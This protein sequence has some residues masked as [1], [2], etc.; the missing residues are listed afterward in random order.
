LQDEKKAPFNQEHHFQNDSYNREA[1]TVVSPRVITPS[2]IIPLNAVQ[3]N[4]AK[5]LVSSGSYQSPAKI[6]KK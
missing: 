6:L 3:K 5:T 2:N 4:E 1:S